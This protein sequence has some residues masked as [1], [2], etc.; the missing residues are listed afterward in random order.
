[1]STCA[2]SAR[3]GWVGRDAY[4]VL[5]GQLEDLAKGVD[6]VSA[7]DGVLLGVANVVV[8]RDE[9]PDRWRP[10]QPAMTASRGSSLSAGLPSSMVW[11]G[12]G[13]PVLGGASSPFSTAAA[14]LRASA[15]R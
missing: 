11:V 15:S 12:R 14:L 5:H 3:A 8:R 2:G 1:M 9:D 13:G 6:G 7:S 4:I 10:G